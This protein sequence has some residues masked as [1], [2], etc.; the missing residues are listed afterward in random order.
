MPTY[1]PDEAVRLL[2]ARLD[3]IGAALARRNDALALISLGSVG[4]QRDRLDEYSDLD[5]YAIVEDSAKERYLA[6]LDW[7]EAAGPIAYSFRNTVDGHKVLYADGVFCEFAVFTLA[8]LASAVGSAAHV[9]WQRPGLA[10]PLELLRIVQPQV[11]RHEQSWLIGEALTNLYVGLG[12]LRRGEALSA[13]RFIQHYAVDHILELA[14]AIEPARPVHRDPFAPE[15][16]VEQRFP[17]LARQLPQFM[18]GYTRSRESALAILAFLEAH[19]DV[20]PVMAEAIRMRA[21]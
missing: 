15:R 4:Q 14:E 7:L 21:M 20:A 11:S 13:M 19:Y 16:R 17:D 2:L 10:S 1:R 8:E 12:R 9:V 18:Q 3:A 6:S 5:F